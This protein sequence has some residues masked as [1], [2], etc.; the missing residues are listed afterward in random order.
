LFFRGVAEIYK[1]K[2]VEYNCAAAKTFLPILL[3]LPVWVFTTAAIRN[4]IYMR[5]QS[6]SSDA[7]E[8]LMQLSNGGCLWFDNLVI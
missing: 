1:A 7:M 3:Q 5:H 4:L 2:V 6:G 8:R